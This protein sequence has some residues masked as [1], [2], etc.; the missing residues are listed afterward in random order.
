MKE[1]EGKITIS[2]VSGYDGQYVEIQIEDNGSRNRFVTVKLSLENFAKA[3]MNQGYIPM[4]FETGNLAVVG[5][6]IESKELIFPVD[7]WFH[8]KDFAEENCQKFA[9]DGWTASTYFRSQSSIQLHD[10]GKHYAHGTQF[11]YV[12][13]KDQDGNKN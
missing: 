7:G 4:T 12:N 1:L 3:I 11:R 2:K 9:E 13:K 5:K 6:D 10:D 8:A